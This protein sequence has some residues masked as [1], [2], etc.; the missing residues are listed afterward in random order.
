MLLSI[1]NII[2]INVT[3]NWIYRLYEE[4]ILSL[5]EFLN[6]Y[7]DNVNVDIFYSDKE[8]FDINNYTL[9]NYNKIF[10][11]GDIEYLK[12]IPEDQ[13]DKLYFINIEQ[14]SH[15]YYYIMIRHVL[16]STRII[17]YSEENVPYFKDIYKS[18]DLFPPYFKY[19]KD[20]GIKDKS[21]DILSITNNRYRNEI[22]NKVC[23][24]NKYNTINLEN[25]Y[26][27]ERNDYFSKSKIYIN[28]HC[29]D[30]HQTM[31]MIRIVNLI[32][33]KVIII[34]Q[35]S[36]ND[37]LLFFKKYIIFCNDMNDLNHY[38]DVILE[39][40]D[41]YYDQIYGDFDPQLYY[42][43]IKDNVDKIIFE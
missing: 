19:N 37:E 43:Y 8:T 30:M 12:L 16:E 18:V 29:S 17:D 5:K 27:R 9:N 34:S 28:I 21:I 11:T 26:G 41:Y 10:F 22:F 1:M 13:K 2:I 32:M 33:N 31:E 38:I 39:N 7:Y 20:I 14:M 6:E 24:N 40:Y 23:E 25:V 4:Y 36:I 3:L 42:K 35:K 15:P